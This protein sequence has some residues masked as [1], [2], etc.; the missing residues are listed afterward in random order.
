MPKVW[1]KSVLVLKVMEQKKVER[2]KKIQAIF[3]KRIGF[4]DG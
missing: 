1:Q 3:R 4:R 2:V